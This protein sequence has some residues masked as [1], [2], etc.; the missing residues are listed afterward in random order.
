M[1][2]AQVKPTL[3]N[4]PNKSLESTSLEPSSPEQKILMTLEEYRAIA[5]TAEAHLEYRNGEI[6]AM[7][8][9]T[10][11]HSEIASNFLI[12]LGFLLRDTDFHLYNSDL[13][14]WIPEHQCGT[15]TEWDLYRSHGN[16]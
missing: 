6:I 16:Q 12:C 3:P 5:E 14:V 4:K 9:G 2:V 11:T 15:Y 7:S 10:A 8:G 13:R 1:V